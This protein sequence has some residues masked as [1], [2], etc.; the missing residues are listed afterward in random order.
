MKRAIFIAVF[1]V[2]FSQVSF[3]QWYKLQTFDKGISAITFF[4][5][6]DQPQIGFIGNGDYADTKDDP[7]TR[8]WKTTDGG[9]SWIP[10]SFTR[11]LMGGITNF[12]FKDSLV[13]WFSLGHYGV[14][15]S[16]ASCYKTI[17][18]GQSWFPTA[19]STS[20]NY[21]FNGSSSVYFNKV[22]NLLFLSS[23]WK[24][25]MVSN[26]FGT[27]WSIATNGINPNYTNGFA[28]ANDNEG[29]LSRV[30]TI[31][32][33]F[34][35]L[36]KTNDG[37]V[38]WSKINFLEECWQPLAI[39]G[40]SIYYLKGDLSDNVYRSDDAG[41]TW[42]LLSN[43][44]NSGG[45][46]TGNLEKLY[47]H[48]D[49]VFVSTDQ[50]VSWRNICGPKSQSPDTRFYA[51]YG[52]IYAAD[53]YRQQ[54]A[55][56]PEFGRLWVNTTGNGSGERLL[57]SHSSGN[58]DF[59]LTAGNIWKT[60]ITLPDTF[61]TIQWLKLDSLVFTVKYEADVLSLRSAE[62]APGWKLISATESFGKAS[63][64]LLRESSNDR[65]VP[66]ASL[67]FQANIA[68][69]KE[70]DVYIDSVFYN[71]GEFTS[72]EVLA[73]EKLHITINDECGDS[74]IRE[75]INSKPILEIVSIHPNPTSGDVTVDFSSLLKA[76]V[77][78]QVLNDIG[79]VDIEETIAASIGVNHHTIAIPSFWNGTFFIRLQMG[80]DVV[81]GKFVKQ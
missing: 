33:D 40:T 16:E 44:P 67:T 15:I 61:S 81:T 70:S 27:T 74:T 14:V 51:T 47:L 36:Y 58:R 8:V 68:R 57:L 7:D 41:I 20:P 37:G 49:G 46:I 32:G 59:V 62:A 13:G 23:W 56:Y 76:D 10:S 73:S 39:E 3:G 52:Y 45:H 55:L 21:Y 9:I 80:K 79:Y 6:N 31:A 11:S 24:W 26:D 78:L 75:F 71:A 17:D 19:F 65:G 1:F 60:D 22:N 66:V 38:T 2:L 5:T 53:T 48:G 34:F 18:G 43:V 4:E 64:K 35:E 50:G 30:S 29:I 69:E 54:T 25:L 12:C 28:F 72:C 77:H 63:V 42:K